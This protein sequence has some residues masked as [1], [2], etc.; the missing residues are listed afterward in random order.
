MEFNERINIENYSH[1]ENRSSNSFLTVIRTILVGLFFF[2]ALIF[3]LNSSHK[4]IKNYQ[5]ELKTQQ[6]RNL[7]EIE[8]DWHMEFFNQ[9]NSSNEEIEIIKNI[10][11]EI[12]IKNDYKKEKNDLILLNIDND[13]LIA[14]SFF[15][16]RTLMI[17]NSS[18][19]NKYK[20]K[21][22]KKDKNENKKSEYFLAL[23]KNR[24]ENNA[25][26]NKKN[27]LIIK[28]DNEAISIN[29]GYNADNKTNHISNYYFDYINKFRK[30]KRKKNF[31]IFLKNKNI[32]S[33]FSQLK[34]VSNNSFDYL[35]KSNNFAF[36]NEE[37]VILS[38][39]SQNKKSKINR[40]L[41]GKNN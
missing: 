33:N 41:L 19:V 16:N 10:K 29:D 21:S 36:K 23:T 9:N 35:I 8:M 27:N 11:D 4:Y 32:L 5:E 34:N 37:N 22:L 13:N 40:S 6:L 24:N 38:R 18:R 7:E 15:S 1:T 17:K 12:R 25:D 30:Q 31:P 20:N 26:N 3:I 28:D 2:G 14:D 39:N